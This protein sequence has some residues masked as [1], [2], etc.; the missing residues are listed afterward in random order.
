MKNL[1][2]IFAAIAVLA[3]TAVAGAEFAAAQQKAEGLR[4]PSFVGDNMVLQQN[5]EVNVWGWAKPK[6][7]PNAR[8]GR[9]R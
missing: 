1:K 7:K 2:R 6:A 4:L 8:K 3:L 5:A 9:G